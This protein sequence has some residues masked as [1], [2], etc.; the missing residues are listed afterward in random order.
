MYNAIIHT[1]DHNGLSK[2]ILNYYGHRLSRTTMDPHGLYGLEIA[3]NPMESKNEHSGW[4]GVDYTSY[5]YNSG[6]CLEN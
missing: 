2:T 5:Y 6:F 3:L 4:G 1:M